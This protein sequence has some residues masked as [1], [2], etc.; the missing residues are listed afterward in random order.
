MPNSGPSHPPFPTNAST[1]G[2]V[3]AQGAQG[4]QG[5][6]APPQGSR[7]TLD[8]LAEDIQGVAAEAM[9]SIEIYKE[10]VETLDIKYSVLSPPGRTFPPQILLE[11]GE[12]KYSL[13]YKG[14]YVRICKYSDLVMADFPL[15]DNYI[16]R[17]REFLSVAPF[18]KG[19][20]Q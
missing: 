11:M 16:D 13:G 8:E 3:G 10:V 2:P 4:V 12:Y 17:I 20:E 15:E 1:L 18:L 6:Q 9:L 5:W 14:G 19:K 7:I